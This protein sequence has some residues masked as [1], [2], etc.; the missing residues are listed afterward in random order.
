MNPIR[1]LLADDHTLFR[2]GLASLLEKEPGFEVI[3]E[4]QDGAE[5]IRPINLILS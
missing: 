3:G 4:A 2:K 1:L 5:A